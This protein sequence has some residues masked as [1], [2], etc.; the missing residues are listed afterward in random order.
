MGRTLLGINRFHA[1]DKNNS[2]ER[3]FVNIGLIR[4][5]FH[6]LVLQ[7]KFLQLPLLLL[8]TQVTPFCTFL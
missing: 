5:P 6:Q 8:P 2:L 1:G 4:N 7:S 3:L